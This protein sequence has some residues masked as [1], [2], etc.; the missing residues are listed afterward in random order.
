[1]TPIL[2]T[3]RQP[4]GH[5]TAWLLTTAIW[6]GERPKD[7]ARAWIAA[8]SDGVWSTGAGL[9]V[10]VGL[11]GGVANGGVEGTR[12]AQAATSKIIIVETTSKRFMV[13]TPFK[14]QTI[15]TQILFH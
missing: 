10:W 5:C 7:F 9:D 1:M 14:T 8:R 13:V 4:S 2:R 11:L 12:G 6:S 15:L 3:P